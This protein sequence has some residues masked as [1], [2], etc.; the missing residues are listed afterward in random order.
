[1]TPETRAKKLVKETLDRVCRERGLTYKVD[2]FAGTAFVNNLDAGGVV[3]GHPV[4]IE[5]KRFDEPA[6]LTERQRLRKREYEM[7]GAFVHAIV[8]ETSLE[9]FR[10]WL[11]TLEPREPHD[12]RYT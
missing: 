4:Y 10:W 6:N 1:M 12:P 5:V 8:D 3:A 2:W 11:M 9:F 7:A